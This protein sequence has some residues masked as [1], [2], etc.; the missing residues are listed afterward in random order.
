MPVETGLR[1]TCFFLCCKAS[2]GAICEED[3]G[4][5]DDDDEK[6]KRDTNSETSP[7]TII[8]TCT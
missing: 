2:V 1:E 3:D 4:G 5:D 8:H 6:K 7:P